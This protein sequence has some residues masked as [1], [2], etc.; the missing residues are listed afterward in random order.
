MLVLR[1]RSWAHARR[2]APPV[3]AALLVCAALLAEVASPA[4]AHVASE[5]LNVVVILTDDE[6]YDANATMKNVHRLLA[7]HGVTFTEFHITTSECCPSRASILTGQY[8]HHHHVVG[9]FGQTGYPQFDESNTLAT[10]LAGAGYSTALVGKYLNDYTLFGDHHVPPGWRTWAAMDSVP[11]ERYYRYTLNLDRRLVYHGRRP[12]DYSTTVLSNQAARFLRSAKEP[13]FLYYA[14]IAPHLPAIPAPTDVGSLHSLRPLREPSFD[15][16]DIS[17]KPWHTFHPRTLSAGGIA[18]VQD[19][20]RTRQL[21]S[22]RAVDRSVARLVS[23]LRE[24]GTLDRTVIIYSSDNGFLLGEHRLGGKIWPYEESMHVPLVIRTPWTTAPSRDD[25]FVL[26]TD[27]APTIAELAG[28]RPGRPQDGRSLVPLLHGRAPA[29]RV[30]FL[31]E[32]RGQPLLRAGGPPRFKAVHDRRFLYVEYDNGWQELYDHRTD[33]YEVRNVASD[34][35][36]AGYKARLA[37]RLA[38][39]YATPAR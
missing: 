2:W 21:E 15:E 35:K 4:H 24:R 39:L 25:H 28:V 31:E 18:Y 38:A 20:I 16:R 29:W 12:T 19:E 11:E 5:P 32:Y 17:D 30:D 9:N 6:R 27:L 10:W 33:P 26:N 34:P 7:A 36:Y 1:A 37:R 14:P 23:V 13:F 3:I 22:L 8:S